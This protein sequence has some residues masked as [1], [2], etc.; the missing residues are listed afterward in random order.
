MRILFMAIIVA[1]ISAAT[2]AH[3][4]NYNPRYPVC[5]K[6]IENFGGERNARIYYSLPQCSQRAAGLGATCILNPFYR[7]PR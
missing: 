5:M 3:A 7:G 4:Q 1:A 2:S 6:V